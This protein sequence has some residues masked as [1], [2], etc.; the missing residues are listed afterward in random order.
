MTTTNKEQTVH[1]LTQK[2]AVEKLLLPVERLPEQSF[3]TPL[4]AAF[5]PQALKAVEEQRE[6]AELLTTMVYTHLYSH[7]VR[8]LGS[9]EKYK[10]A[11]ETFKKQNLSAG[12]WVDN[13]GNI[14]TQYLP[15]E[16]Q[17][18]NLKA[19]FK[20]ANFD[21]NY[22]A[23]LTYKAK[24]RI[25]DRA[26]SRLLANGETTTDARGFEKRP[27]YANLSEFTLNQLE[28][29]EAEVENAIEAYENQ[30]TPWDNRQTLHYHRLQARLADI[31]LRMVE[32]RP[33]LNTS[34]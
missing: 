7:F 9:Q 14:R 11:C 22:L 6:E 24:Q 21:K 2:P 18:Q 30:K 31:R 8:G 29:R 26:K 4:E 17:L 33:S 19:L 1:R 34:V 16:E 27:T 12:D 25:K 15:I 20:A 5:S 10:E 13:E 32:L 23:E 28:E 3:S